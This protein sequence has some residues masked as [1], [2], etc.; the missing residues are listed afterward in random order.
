MS[1]RRMVMCWHFSKGK[2]FVKVICCKNSEK[3]SI[4]VPLQ[5]YCFSNNSHCSPEVTKEVVQSLQSGVEFIHN[6]KMNFASHLN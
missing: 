1:N 6:K 2:L 5:W 4:L 3:E